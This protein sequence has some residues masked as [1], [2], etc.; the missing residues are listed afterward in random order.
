MSGLDVALAIAALAVGAVLFG[1]AAEEVGGWA[2]LGVLAPY[3]A[4]LGIMAAVMW[5]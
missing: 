4:L 2:A 3:V 5:A 1:F